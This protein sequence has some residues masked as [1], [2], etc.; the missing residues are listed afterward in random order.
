MPGQSQMALPMVN[1]RNGASA[2]RP[3]A[4]PPPSPQPM[5]APPVLPVDQVGPVSLAPVPR[6]VRRLTTGGVLVVAAVAALGSYEHM[7]ALGLAV[8]EGWRAWLLP[9]PVDGLGLVAAMTMLVR[10]WSGQRAGWLA[11]TALVL[12]LGVSLAGNVAAAEPT[13]AARLWAAWPPVGLLL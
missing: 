3:P 10:R 9:F 6:W 8:G 12:S 1:R 4:A 13:A 7:R 11:W 5:A 2:H